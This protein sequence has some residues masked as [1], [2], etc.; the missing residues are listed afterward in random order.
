MSDP[1]DSN[2]LT[3]SAWP[4]AQARVRAVSW[5]LSV[6]ASTSTSTEG[7]RGVRLWGE[8]GEGLGVIGVDGG[9]EPRIGM[10]P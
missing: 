5:L 3:S 1:L 8:A 4:P 6:T 9:G 2:K 10:F 7:Y